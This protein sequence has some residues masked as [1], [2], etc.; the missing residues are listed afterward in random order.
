MASAADI[1]FL[2]FW[3]NFTFSTIFY[4]CN[5]DRDGAHSWWTDPRLG[6]ESCNFAGMSPRT[7]TALR[8]A[9]TSGFD[10][11]FPC[12][13][14]S[15]R[16]WRCGGDLLP[17][18][19]LQSGAVRGEPDRPGHAEPGVDE[20]RTARVTDYTIARSLLHACG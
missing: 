19:Q 13:P 20:I 6:C 18:D 10:A 14:R 3:L 8:S 9:F 12:Q 4:Y 16:F 15:H 5:L 2:L 17:G 1:A 7:P 11:V